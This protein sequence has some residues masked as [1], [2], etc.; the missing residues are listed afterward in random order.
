M[1][2][3]IKKTAR[4][5][6]YHYSK[7]LD[8]FR[9]LNLAERAAV[10][11]ELSPYVQQTIISDLKR[12]E[13]VELL[14]HMDLQQAENILARITEERRKKRIISLLKGERRQ[15][16]EYFLRF[17]PKAT[18]RLLNF[19]YLLLS[20]STTIG[21]AASAI[22]E[23]YRETGKLPEIL[24]HKNGELTGEVP[25]SF[26]VRE[27][28]SRCLGNYVVSVRTVQYHDDV[29]EVVS[30]FG[31]SKHCKVVVLDRDGS[32]VG[33]I[34]S[35]DALEL[36]GGDPTHSLFHFAGV[37]SSERPFDSVSIKFRNRWKWLI[38]NLVT[39]F[40]AAATVGLFEDTIAQIVVLAMYLP[41][42]AGMGGNAATQSLAV[43]VRGITVG[44]VSLR[45]SM[46]AMRREI[47]TGL[48]NGIINGVI[49]AVVA[50]ALTGTPMLGLVVGLA[51]VANLVIAAFF[52]TITPLVI[53][54]FGKDPAT[55][56]TIF[57]TTATDVFGFFVFLGLATL[58]LL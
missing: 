53:K 1:D 52:G 8:L 17:H 14:D 35:D 31:A 45:N 3:K 46:P 10:F 9:K 41:I 20:D 21:Q 47:T 50:L 56:A 25:L 44:E 48:L 15:K 19:N 11:S 58:I 33:I 37:S 29:R 43:M 39:S 42:V 23:H 24:V 51:M 12:G 4:H 22:D 5:I 38:L 32:V 6:T 28:N 26:L 18:L 36:L 16:A 54:H 49:V 27:P 7:R 34:Y 57:I 40:L 30:L 2:G 55:S 13:I